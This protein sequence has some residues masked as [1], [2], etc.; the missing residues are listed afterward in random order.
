VE[1][2]QPYINGLPF[3]SDHLCADCSEHFDRLK[4]YLDEAR[5]PYE[6]VPRLV[7]GLDYYVRTAFEMVS[8]ELG[9]QNAL[10]G[11]GRYDGLSEALGGPKVPA[12]GFAMG[13]DRIVML[14]SEEQRAVKKWKPELFLA[15]MG[16]GAFRKAQEVARELRHQGTVCCFDFSEGSLKS[17]MRLANRLGAGHV[18]IIGEQELERARYTIKRLSD[19]RQWEVTLPELMRYLASPNSP[20]AG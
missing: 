20:Q 8:G 5:I 10:L 14:L 4:L 9:A 2:C 15:H 16:E 6:I 1:R 19:S 7:R 11:G 12:L 17:Q 18:L 13:L 3:I